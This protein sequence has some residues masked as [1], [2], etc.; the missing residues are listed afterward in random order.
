LQP[1]SDHDCPCVTVVGRSLSHAD[2]T[3]CL[4]ALGS[5]HLRPELAAPLGVWMSSQLARCVDGR[6]GWRLSGAVAVLGCCTSP[7]SSAHAP[8]AVPSGA[9]GSLCPANRGSSSPWLWGW[10]GHG[11]RRRPADRRPAAGRRGR[12]PALARPPKKW[13]A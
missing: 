10:S 6:G 5:R 12:R 8:V 4:R 11:P 13:S 3:P 9:S 2:R 7:A 1:P